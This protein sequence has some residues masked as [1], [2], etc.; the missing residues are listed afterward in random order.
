MRKFAIS[1][2]HGCYQ[3][4]KTLLEK[5]DL[6]PTD[7]LYLLGD[8]INRGKDT[9]RV[10]DHI[11]QLQDL[12]YFI[13]CLRGNHE[14]VLLR[15]LRDPVWAKENW[16]SGV[17]KETLESFRV[18]RAF[19][20]PDRYIDFIRDLDFYL[21]VDNYILVHAGLN[22]RTSY[23]FKDYYSQLWINDWYADVDYDWLENRY[24]VH[25]HAATTKTEIERLFSNFK[26][27][28]Y[29]NIDAGCSHHKPNDPRHLCAYEMTRGELIFVKN[30]EGK[31]TVNG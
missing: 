18:E 2:I 7:R 31:R 8:Y 17:G 20:I 14:A 28:Q 29:L 10:I 16:E 6:Q 26:I 25:G 19:E 12:G 11:F 22:F 4:F 3:T 13:K 15:A 21:E 5:I 23:P 1:D 27:D 30:V 9:K 24:I